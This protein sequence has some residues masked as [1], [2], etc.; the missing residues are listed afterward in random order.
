[1]RMQ[2]LVPYNPDNRSLMKT[3]GTAKINMRGSLQSAGIEV[4]TKVYPSSVI[5]D[6]NETQMIQGMLARGG[7]NYR[8]NNFLNELPNYTGGGRLG[9]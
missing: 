3:R 1:M 7:R 4:T 8:P 9:S 2:Q 5:P 6:K